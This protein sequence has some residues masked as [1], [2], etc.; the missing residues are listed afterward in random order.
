MTA[1]EPRERAPSTFAE[2]MAW[3]AAA[4][5]RS[6]LPVWYGA[7]ER[8][9]WGAPS[10][11]WQF[12]ADHDALHIALRA[13]FDMAGETRVAVE[14]CKIASALTCERLCQVIW[15]E[16]VGQAEYFDRF[17]CFPADQIAFHMVRP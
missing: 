1:F 17:G 2:L 4:G 12:R 10:A 7:S 6:P 16:V 8:A 3:H 13:P 5:P 9:I 14:A 11:N 15:R